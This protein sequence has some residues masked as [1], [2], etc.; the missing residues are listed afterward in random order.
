LRGRLDGWTGATE[1]LRP[2]VELHGLTTYLSFQISSLEL[3]LESSG[4]AAALEA[5][6]ARCRQLQGTCLR[7][8]DALREAYSRLEQLNRRVHAHRGSV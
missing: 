8:E 1:G 2:A 3:A 4:A 6:E 7:K 5:C